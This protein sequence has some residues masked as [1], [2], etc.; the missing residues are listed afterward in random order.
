MGVDVHSVTGRHPILYTLCVCF[1][2]M[3]SR[4][5]MFDLPSYLSSE[6]IDQIALFRLSFQFQDKHM[7]AVHCPRRLLESGKFSSEV[8]NNMN[9]LVTSEKKAMKSHLKYVNYANSNQSSH[10]KQFGDLNKP[11]L[12]KGSPHSVHPSL[13]SKKCGST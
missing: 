5:P 4:C 12:M 13:K 1:C 8:Q 2:F 10:F 3:V 11:C 6:I 7:E 9:N